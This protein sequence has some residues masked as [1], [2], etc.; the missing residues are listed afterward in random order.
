MSIE[1]FLKKFLQDLL[2]LIFESDIAVY[3]QKE[4]K[5][6]L[7]GKENLINERNKTDDPSR[8]IRFIKKDVQAI[9]TGQKSNLQQDRISLSNE[10]LISGRAS[11]FSAF[12]I[13]RVFVD[14]RLEKKIDGFERP[15][16][17]NTNQTPH[18][19]I[20]PIRLS[21]K[22]LEMIDSKSAVGNANRYIPHAFYFRP[23]LSR[24]TTFKG[25][26]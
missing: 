9:L 16:Y 24:F 12:F 6:L 25:I 22:I 18:S 13:P 19:F 3:F 8:Q 17:F 14:V 10:K 7:R 4:V 5:M 15:K 26:K 1:I 23:S 20:C 2:V 11:R 21:G